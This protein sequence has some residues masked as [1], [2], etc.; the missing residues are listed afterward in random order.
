MPNAPISIEQT[1]VSKIGIYKI[2]N[3]V[4]EDLRLQNASDA[5]IEQTDVSKIGIYKNLNSVLEDL[6]LQNA[7]ETSPNEL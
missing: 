1:D 5:G 4:L 7:S 3:S 6:R 2:L